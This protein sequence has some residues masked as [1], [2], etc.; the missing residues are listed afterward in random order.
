ME[1]VTLS[2]WM[3]G[4]AQ[5]EAAVAI[6]GSAS[7]GNDPRFDRLLIQATGF[8]QFFGTKPLR[9]V[10][11]P[12]LSEGRAPEEITVGFPEQPD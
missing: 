4:H 12:G 10:I 11:A 7:E 8:A 9:H 2:H 3:P 6:V 1:Q 5:L